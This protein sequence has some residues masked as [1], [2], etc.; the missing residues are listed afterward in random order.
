MSAYW[1]MNQRTARII[2]KAV[3]L[4]RIT[5]TACV[6]ETG[7]LTGK[8]AVARLASTQRKALLAATSAYKTT[9]NVYALQAVAGLFP[10]DL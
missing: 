3:F 9:S 1:G 6:W 2:Y 5:Y 10:L 8:E 4:P 7:V